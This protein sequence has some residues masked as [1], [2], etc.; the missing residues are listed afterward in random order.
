MEKAHTLPRYSCIVLDE[1]DDLTGHHFSKVIQTL[2][3]FFRKCGQLNLFIILILPDFFELKP[4]YALTRSNYLCNV[5][6]VDEFTRG[7]FDFFGPSNKRKLFLNGKRWKDYGA[8]QPNY[9]GRFV[10]LYTVDEEAY[11][12]AKLDDLNESE[13]DEVST[14]AQLKNYKIELLTKMHEAFKDI[15][16]ADLGKVFGMG[17]STAFNYIKKNSENLEI[18]KSEI[19]KNPHPESKYNNI[20]I[21]EE[22]MS[23]QPPI[24]ILSK[25]L[26]VGLANA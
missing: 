2:N 1:G 23:V 18:S 12:Q 10:P 24:N 13:D 25:H 4:A 9:Q 5:K 17:R 7:Y 15:P 26:E 22:K 14:K 19:P 16:I 6:F 20:T 3:K 11:R 21:E 8:A